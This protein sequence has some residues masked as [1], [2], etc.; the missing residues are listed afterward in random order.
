M[1]RA[2]LIAVF[3]LLPGGAAFASTAQWQPWVHLRL[4]V[5]VAGPRSDGTLVATAGGRL[6]LISSD[7]VVR[8]FAPGYRTNPGTEPYITIG[9]G[10]FGKDDV[11]ALE[12]GKP[13]G[14]VRIDASGRSSRFASFVG[15]EALSGITLDTTGAFGRRLL[16]TGLHRGR[17]VLEAVDCSGQISVIARDAPAVEGGIVVAPV[18]FGLHAGKLIGPSERTG[19][20]VAIAADGSSSVIARSG[21]PAGG[22]IGVESAGFVPIGFDGAAYLADRSSPGSPT[23]GTDSLLSIDAKTLRAAGVRDGD[24]LVATEAVGRTIA[25]RCTTSCTVTKIAEASKAAHPEGHI[26][27]TRGGTAVA[28]SRRP[29]AFRLGLA[30]ALVA[31][32]FA[33]TASVRARRE[34]NPSP[35]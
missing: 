5:D 23:K 11:F 25:V 6:Y 29:V 16:V 30:A 20:I 8:P 21:L 12:L 34:R 2:V 27:F 26:L 4:V 22:D 32:A 35:P 9:D 19:D 24:L 28:R 7:R 13:L 33:L 17:T 1:R 31:A 14:V 3:V 18:T 15:V 10:C